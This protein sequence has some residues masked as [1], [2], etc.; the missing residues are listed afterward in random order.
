MRPGFI[1]SLVL[2][3]SLCMLTDL[4]SSLWELRNRETE[5]PKEVAGRQLWCYLSEW[6]PSRQT[7]APPSWPQLTQGLTSNI[8]SEAQGN[9]L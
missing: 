2:L 8:S 1:L 6:H 5:K 3:A 7:R 9:A 4:A